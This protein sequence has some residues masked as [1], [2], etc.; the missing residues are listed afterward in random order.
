MGVNCSCAAEDLELKQK[1][2]RLNRLGLEA[3]RT[4]HREDLKENADTVKQDND[5]ALQT[6]RSGLRRPWH[7]TVA[8]DT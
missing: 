8:G 6:L 3:S 7:V 2:Q 4:E 5:E 1:A